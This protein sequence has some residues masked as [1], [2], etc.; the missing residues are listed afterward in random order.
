M[1]GSF[2]PAKDAINRAKHGLS[3]AFGDKIFGDGLH[4]VEPSFRAV[5]GE[6]RFKVIGRVDGRLYTGVF[7]WRGG[8]PR[9]MSVRRSNRNE[10]RLYLD[11]G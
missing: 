9:Y 3:L 1:A 5:D 11:P 6:A 2:D 7:A 8:E 4:I 10:E